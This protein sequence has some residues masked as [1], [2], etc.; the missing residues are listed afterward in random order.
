[1]MRLDNAAAEQYQRGR[2]Y[3]SSRNGERSENLLHAIS[4]YETALQFYTFE[5]FPTKWDAIQQDMT[6]AYR[7]LIEMRRNETRENLPLSK[8]HAPP[9]FTWRQRLFF[10]LVVLAFLAIPVVSVAKAYIEQTSG[11]ACAS[12]TLT[13]DGSTVLE[14]F[15][16]AAAEKYMSQCPGATI[17][18]G[19]GA[20]KIGLQGVEQDKIQIGDSDIFASPVQR[21]LVDHQVAI[22]V[23]VLILNQKVVGL[24]NL[25]T[26]QIQKIYTGVYQNWN[27]VCD[28]SQHC[29]DLPIVAINRTNGSGTRFTFEKYVL[30][31]IATVPGIGFDQV[32]SSDD[33]VQ[34]IEDI[35][36]SIGYTS[37]YL[38][39]QA[40]QTHGVTI[41]S[42]EG[43][44]PPNFSFGEHDS[45]RFWN[46]EHMYTHG[47][48]SPLTRN[49]ISYITYSNDIQKLLSSYEFLH[50]TDISQD[51]RKKHVLESQ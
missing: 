26:A 7:E 17:T 46:I 28:V 9:S 34:E 19:G 5:C 6:I 12:G 22:G 20:S 1:M 37:L 51:I 39:R 31:G 42:I 47:Q 29:P 24:H 3:Y 36:G 8:P 2:E 4:C 32:H 25:T 16:K 21:N 14:P 43:K 49:F 45:Y 11:L 13:I 23:F 40:V 27:E 48:E 41:V 44:Q 33:A 10:G 35:P 15:V 50:I 18:V 30:N 38:A